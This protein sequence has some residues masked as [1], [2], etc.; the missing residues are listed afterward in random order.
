VSASSVCRASAVLQTTGLR[1]LKA[2]EQR[3]L[4]VRKSDDHDARRIFIELSPDT[5][6]AL[7]RYI[8]EVVEPRR[9]G[10]R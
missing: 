7:R 9:A 4:V 6:E 1:W 10:T 5:S 8:R 3:G 2:L